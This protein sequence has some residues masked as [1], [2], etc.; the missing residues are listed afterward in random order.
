[1]SVIA[2]AASASAASPVVD[3]FKH[4]HKQGG[5]AASSTDLSAASSTTDSS[6]AS[7]TQAPATNHGLF[8]SL[9][10]SLQ[11]MIGISLTAPTSAASAAA[12]AT[13]ITATAASSAAH[14]SNSLGANVNARV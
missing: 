11:Q 13:G 8:S 14:A 1:M 7:S 4:G 9:L 5:H 3:L 12:A 2:S 10:D 6:A